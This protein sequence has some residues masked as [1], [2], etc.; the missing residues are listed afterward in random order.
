VL[1]YCT[2]L[3]TLSDSEIGAFLAERS[4]KDG[5]DRTVD[6]TQDHRRRAD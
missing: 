6:F 5:T 4:G 1:D 2:Y 3:E